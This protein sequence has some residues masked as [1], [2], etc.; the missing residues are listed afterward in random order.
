MFGLFKSSP[1]V[2]SELGEFV[3][4]RGFW[5]G[6]INLVSRNIPFLL[7]GNKEKPDPLAL[8]LVRQIQAQYASWRPLIETALFEHY[9]P[10]AEAQ[11]DEELPPGSEP[12]PLI[13]S[14][15]QV[16]PYV[17]LVHVSVLPLDGKLTI[18]L[19][20]TTAWDEEHTLG[21][22]FLNGAFL[23]LCGSV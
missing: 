14:A 2:D 11:A 16:W 7:L 8:A 23:E 10:Y 13:T 18:E 21:A 6:N 17:T 1:F 20:Y 19:G 12:F 9:S 3:R 5:R 22:R 15:S 4:S